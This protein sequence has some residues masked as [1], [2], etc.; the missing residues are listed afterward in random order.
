MPNSIADIL[1]TVRFNHA[2]CLQ[3][4]D[5]DIDPIKQ[6][7]FGDFQESVDFAEAFDGVD[8]VELILE[9]HSACVF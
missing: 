4:V 9:I 2:W 7:K 5:A 6:S 1:A 8:F 3:L